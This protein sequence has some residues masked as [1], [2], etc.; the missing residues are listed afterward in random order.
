LSEQ[1]KKFEEMKAVLGKY[2]IKDEN[3]YQNSSKISQLQ[4]KI[5]SIADE[6]VNVDGLI[7]KADETAAAN[8]ENNTEL[9]TGEI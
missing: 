1:K 6:L 7:K 4:T 9:L 5:D 8:K 3:A 2:R